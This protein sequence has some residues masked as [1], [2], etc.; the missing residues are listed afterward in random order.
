MLQLVN[1]QINFVLT[2]EFKYQENSC[3]KRIAQRPVVWVPLSWCHKN[4]HLQWC[5]L[6]WNKTATGLPCTSQV[7]IY[8]IYLLIVTINWYGAQL[9]MLTIITELLIKASNEILT[10]LFSGLYLKLCMQLK[11]RKLL[12]ISKA[13]Q[14]CPVSSLI[15]NVSPCI[16]GK[17]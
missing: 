12:G 14:V 15:K 8:S 9:T 17:M 16:N 11:N 1:W 2:Q 4:V 3:K 13:W 5:H 7:K 10:A 6:H